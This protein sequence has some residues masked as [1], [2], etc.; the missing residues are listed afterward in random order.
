MAPLTTQPIESCSK[1]PIG[2]QGSEW[3]L[4]EFLASDPFKYLDP[5]GLE[6]CG[7]GPLIYF[8]SWCVDDETWRTFE[9]ES[10][11]EFNEFIECAVTEHVNAAIVVTATAATCCV[12]SADVLE[13]TEEEL[14]R[15]LG[16][17]ENMRRF[18]SPLSRWEHKLRQRGWLKRGNPMRGVSNVFKRGVSKTVATRCFVAVLY[19][20]VYVTWK[21]APKGFLGTGDSNSPPL[22]ICFAA[23][24]QVSTPQG[25]VAIESIRAGDEV[26]SINP[27]TGQS[28][29]AKVASLRKRKYQGSS[30]RVVVGKDE[31]TCTSTHPFLVSLDSVGNIGRARPKTLSSN[32]DVVLDGVGVWV[33]AG[34]LRVG[35]RV[36]TGNGELIEVKL[37]ELFEDSIEVW[38]LEVEQYKNFQIGDSDVVVH[39]S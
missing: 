20:E 38:N 14:R 11:G 9:D 18:I 17:K 31:F 12:L 35:D 36:V 1:D 2:Y 10:L 19:Y 8:G 5:L 24:T 16:P 21:C 4:F 32:E 22:Y 34:D 30:A 15:G 6:V 3:N 27:G 23:G 25:Q 37:L 29:I 39:N 13:K 7:A 28:A 33:E 26:H